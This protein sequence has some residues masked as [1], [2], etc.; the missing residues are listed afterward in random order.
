MKN[1][2]FGCFF[3]TEERKIKLSLICRTVILL[4]LWLLSY[5]AY[6]IVP[7]W[8][9]APHLWYGTPYT[10]Y[11]SGGYGCGGDKVKQLLEEAYDAIV[12]CNTFNNSV[13][14]LD[15]EKHKSNFLS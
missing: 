9:G 1:L 5:D 8:Y 10:G 13:C 7:S 2:N 4:L 11:G 14:F 15:S 3:N 12:G 6:G